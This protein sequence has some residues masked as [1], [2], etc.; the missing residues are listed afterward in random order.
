MRNE[1][2]KRIDKESQSQK[3]VL[4]YI[5]CF[6]LNTILAAINVNKIDYFSLDVEGGEYDVLKSIDFKKT[7]IDSFSIEHN[8]FTDDKLKIKTHLENIGYKTMKE[9]GQDIY[10]VIKSFLN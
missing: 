5:P 8:G 7:K 1:H 4:L 6:S 9:D 3:K 2:D 10:L